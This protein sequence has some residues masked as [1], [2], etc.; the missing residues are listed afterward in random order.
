MKNAEHI[1]A[2]SLTYIH[3]N[4]LQKCS[5]TFTPSCLHTSSEMWLCSSSHQRLESTSPTLRP[6]LV[7]WLNLLWPK[8]YNRGNGMHIQSLFTS[9]PSPQGPQI[10]PYEE[11][12]VTLLLADER[13]PWPE[14]RPYTYE[15]TQA[16][17]DKQFFSWPQMDEATS[18]KQKTPQMSPAFIDDSWCWERWKAW[19]SR[20]KRGW[21]GWMASSTQWTWVWANSRR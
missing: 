14:M 15:R 18:L 11:T 2:Y 3:C 10:L 21:D 6:E 4:K 13:P 19:G 7:F 1:I 5:Q 8:E 9:L 20:D 16:K 12:R 17:E